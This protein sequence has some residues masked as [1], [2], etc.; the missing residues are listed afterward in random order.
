MNS[1]QFVTLVKIV[2]PFELF[3]KTDCYSSENCKHYCNNSNEKRENE[4]P[5]HGNYVIL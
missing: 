3:F 1:N 5:K 4:R 2:L